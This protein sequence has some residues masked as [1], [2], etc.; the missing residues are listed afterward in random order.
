MADR[1]LFAR[2]AKS[3]KRRPP[4]SV[5]QKMQSVCMTSRQLC[6]C[7]TVRRNIDDVFT[8]LGLPIGF[9]LNLFPAFL[10][11]LFANRV[12]AR[13]VAVNIQA[14]NPGLRTVNTAQ[15]VSQQFDLGSQHLSTLSREM[16]QKGLQSR[17]T[18]RFTGKTEAFSL[19]PKSLHSVDTA[20]RHTKHNQTLLYMKFISSS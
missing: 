10:P 1:C 7:R 4:D 2:H 5:V 6:T 14:L 18:R 15:H 17:N 16:Y 12:F 13:A 3:N 19:P 20:D 9:S 8:K 11:R